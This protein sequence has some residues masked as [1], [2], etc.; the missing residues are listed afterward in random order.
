MARK[1]VSPEARKL[2]L[3]PTEERLTPAQ[4]SFGHIDD[5]RSH[6]QMAEA[7]TDLIRM[8]GAN[9]NADQLRDSTLEW[10]SQAI[11]DELREANSHLSLA[12]EVANV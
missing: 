4:K 12:A 7:I 11:L 10:A 1:T 8:V 5:A 2:R 6:V 3:V 9:G